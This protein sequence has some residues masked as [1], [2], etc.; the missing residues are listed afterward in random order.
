MSL[1][2]TSVPETL[3]ASDYPPTAGPSAAPSGGSTSPSAGGSPAA[4]AG[5]GHDCSVLPVLDPVE[6][7]LAPAIMPCG[8][9][10]LCGAAQGQV[11]T[12][13]VSAVT[14]DIVIYYST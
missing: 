2:A 14:G 8:A 5:S 4:E 3:G 1:T 7:R 10:V 6:R 12:F 13:H 11:S 9:P